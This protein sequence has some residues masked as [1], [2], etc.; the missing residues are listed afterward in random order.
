MQLPILEVLNRNFPFTSDSY[1]KFALQKNDCKACSVYNHY[2]QVVQSE[3]NTSSPLVMIIGEAPGK[4]E[5]EQIRPFIGQ[6][7]KLL[8]DTLKKHHDVFNKETTLI[9][10]VIACRPLDNKFPISAEPKLCCDNWL[11]KEIEM[12]KPQVIVCLGNTPLKYVMGETGITKFRGQWKHLRQFKSWAFATFHPSY[13]MRAIR[14]K[15][16]EVIDQFEK[17]FADLAIEC[18]KRLQVSDH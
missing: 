4:D 17:D 1:N 5:V 7:G 12:V 15:N 3:G 13:V 10:N 14:S 2:S 11:Y 16:Q 8:R 9:S 6:A 18:R